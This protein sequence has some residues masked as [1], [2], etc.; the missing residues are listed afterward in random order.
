VRRAVPAPAEI[1][2]SPGKPATPAPAI[3][4]IQILVVDDL[5]DARTMITTVLEAAGGE[6]TVA[7]SGEQALEQLD[8]CRPQLV[9]ADIGMPGMDG[10]EFVRRLRARP[11]DS[12]GEVPTVALTAFG[13][14]LD[15][16]KAL[17]AGFD[18]HLAKPVLP[19][20]LLVVAARLARR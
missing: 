8:L 9:L 13:S 6:V 5:E 18:D 14:A 1:V 16:A 2:S 10:Y 11:P 4:G 19:E 17:A 20:E 12:G 3:D 15:R 7:E